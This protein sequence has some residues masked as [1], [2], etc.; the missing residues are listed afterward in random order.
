MTTSTSTQQ[1][2]VAQKILFKELCN[3]FQEIKSTYR[4]TKH[5][6]FNKFLRRWRDEMV[7]ENVEDGFIEYRTDDTFYPALRLFV[8]SKDVKIRE[9]RIKEAKLNQLV[10]NSIAAMPLNPVPTNYDL[11]VE[12][13][14]N[15]S[16]DRFPV[17]TAKLTIW[18]VNEFL[19]RIKYPNSVDIQEEAMDKLCRQC[20]PNELRF[21]FHIIL[22]NIERYIDMS[23]HTLMRTFHAEADNLWKEGDSL[24]LIC[25]K[26]ADPET[27]NS[28]NLTGHLLCKPFR[29]ML[30]KRLNYNKYCLA[31]IIRYCQRPFYLETKYDGE[32]LIVH[33]YEKIN[34][35]Y[36]TRN[37]VDY[38]NKLGRHYELL[39]SKRIHKYFREE[40]VDCVLDCELLIWDNNL[41]CFGKKIFFLNLCRYLRIKLKSFGSGT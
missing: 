29:P 18:E 26:F 17:N 13:L 19:D 2:T 41:N 28:M 11:L 22:G 8:P 14:V 39:F 36:F 30:L 38:T 20:T 15:M 16:A 35:K 33:K 12:R 5:F 23:G 40:I 3:V 7:K 9:F 4:A 10:C 27:E 1:P 6:V 25:E 34:Y 24:Q 37:G 31:K 21:I 32:H